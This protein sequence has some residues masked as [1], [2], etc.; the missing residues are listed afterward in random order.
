MIQTILEHPLVCVMTLL[1]LIVLTY[2]TNW[3]G[4]VASLAWLDR[5]RDKRHDEAAN[6]HWRAH[7]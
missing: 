5:R 6:E 3:V 7:Q 4:L 1:S 2:V